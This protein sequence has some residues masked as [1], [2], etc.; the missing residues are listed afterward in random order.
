MCSSRP[1]RKAHHKR[2]HKRLQGRKSE[3]SGFGDAVGVFMTGGTHDA[4]NGN[5]SRQ[6]RHV[7][8]ESTWIQ[9]QQ[10]FDANDFRRLNTDYA[11]FIGNVGERAVDEVIRCSRSMCKSCP[12]NLQLATA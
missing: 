3:A 6:R 10:L 11:L 5:Q 12:Q 8:A 1:P 7:L 4:Q 2:Q 9:R